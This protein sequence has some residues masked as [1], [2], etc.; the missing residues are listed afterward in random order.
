MTTSDVNVVVELIC[1]MILKR[2]LLPKILK[3]YQT[4]LL[5]SYQDQYV[6]N[7]YQ[8][9]RKYQL[10]RGSHKLLQLF[11]DYQPIRAQHRPMKFGNRHV[12]HVMAIFEFLRVILLSDQ[13][14]GG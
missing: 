5:H 10:F 7:E 13:S 8:V 2:V 12:H 9:L 4:K 11:P 3:C 1:Y 14:M 6:N